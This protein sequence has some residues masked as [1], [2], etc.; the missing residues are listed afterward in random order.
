MDNGI[1]LN[2]KS[3]LN[4][5]IKL[6]VENNKDKKNDNKDLIKD[7]EISINN[8]RKEKLKEMLISKLMEKYKIINNENQYLLQNEISKFIIG[9]KI[10]D[11]DLK[12]LDEK[13]KEIIS[14]NTKE[15]SKK[16]Q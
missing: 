4:K 11:T 9:E 16:I 14:K 1:K 15:T 8:Q 7:K 2:Q 5:Y 12:N 13:L 10:T 6:E 3:P